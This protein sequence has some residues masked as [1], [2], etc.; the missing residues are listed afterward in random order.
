MYKKVSGLTNAIINAA[1]TLLS[2]VLLTLASCSS[3]P[4]VEKA[5]TI[6]YREGVP[7]ATLVE[8][9]KITVTATEIDPATRKVTLVAPDGSRNTFTAGP[10]DSTLSQ[11][12]A[13]DEVQ[14]TVT[15]QLVVF[16]RKDST[17]LSE[18]PVIAA[19][20]APPG[21][22][23]GVLKSDTVQRIAKVGAVDRERRQVT[24]EFPD[25]AAKTFVFRKEVELQGVKLGDEVVIRTASAVVLSLEK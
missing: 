15:R 18:G 1:P 5:D 25:G 4:K 21:A 19:A 22:E 24:L 13:G 12:K 6:A 16:L 17:A 11:L 8:T 2:A 7:G 20:L 3:A 14:A 23:S 9:Y 10:G